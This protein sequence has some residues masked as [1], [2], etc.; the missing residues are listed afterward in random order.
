MHTSSAIENTVQQWSYHVH[1]VQLLLHCLHRLATPDH[2]HTHLQAPGLVLITT[3]ACMHVLYNA[4]T[5]PDA[6][7]LDR[8]LLLH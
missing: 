2:E 8:H 7:M 5:V 4:C 1:T 6:Q 3:S